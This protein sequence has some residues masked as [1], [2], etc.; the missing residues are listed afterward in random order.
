M[1]SFGYVIPSVGP[2]TE[3]AAFADLVQAGE[4]LRYADV[5]FG[6]HV[7]VPS[8]A[9][10]LTRPDWIDPLTA[11]AFVLGRTT[12]LRAGTDVLV[13][14]YRH[15]ALAGQDGGVAGPDR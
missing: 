9:T 5:W 4:E 15:P 7:V 2:F 1:T 3:P 14:P 10:G 6:D 8:Y 13:A 12:T 11:C